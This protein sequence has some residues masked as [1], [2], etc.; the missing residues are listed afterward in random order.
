[1]VTP[2]PLYT[3]GLKFSDP[4]AYAYKNVQNQNRNH[5]FV[6][7]KIDFAKHEINHYSI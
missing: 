2:L 7:A 3:V 4:S 5:L 6:M 1:M